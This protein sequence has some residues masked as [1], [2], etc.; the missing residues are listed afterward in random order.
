MKIAISI[1]LHGNIF[2]A[3][4]DG[5]AAAFCPTRNVKINNL[6]GAGDAWDAAELKCQVPG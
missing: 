4:S 2:T 1:D 3:W 6:V 5:T